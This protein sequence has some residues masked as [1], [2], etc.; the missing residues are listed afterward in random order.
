MKPS[1][2]NLVRLR[3]HHLLCLQGYQG[4]GY[5][6]DFKKNLEKTLDIL[7][8]DENTL[9][10]VKSNPDDLC[11]YCPNL[12]N[13]LCGLGKDLD[14]ISQEELEKNNDIIVKMDKIAIEKGKIDLNKKYNINY[15]YNII[16]NNFKT[17]KDV[18]D[19]CG[20]CLWAKCCLFYQS[21]E[22]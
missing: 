15:L 8:N 20:T 10:T 9:V 5:S 11:D 18:E 17:I 14:T 19:V 3:G 6:E 4:Y 21:R 16:N 13:N 1:T 22:K 2:S 12:K 7:K